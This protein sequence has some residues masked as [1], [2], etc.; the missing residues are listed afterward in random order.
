[1]PTK[2]A[3]ALT[4]L[5]LS[6]S[7]SG[8]P[9]RSYQQLGSIDDRQPTRFYYP[10]AGGKIEA[11]LTRPA[12]DGPFPLVILLHG[13]S[14]V[15]RGAEQVLATAQTFSREICFATLAISLPGYGGSDVVEGP[16]EE[17]TRQV[18]QDGVAFAKNLEWVDKSH[19]FFY[20]V[21]RGAI[22]AAAMLN[23]VEGISGAVLYSGAYDLGRL[24][25]DT[26]SFWVRKILNPKG[27]ANPKLFN[28]LAEG[29]Q[30]SVPTLILHGEQ[31]HVIPV[32]QARLLRDRLQ[33]AGVYHQLVVYPDRGHFLPRNDVRRRSMEF[34]KRFVAPACPQDSHL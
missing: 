15:G 3:L 7:C 27:A 26:P 33:S 25:R 31:D 22:I 24:Y 20:G 30:W 17:T 13:H 5:L 1:M 18:V 10:S 34:L 28:L 12:G 16:V 21:S 6:L 9:I 4:S 29:A 11:Y 8:A 2:K 14:F 23:D 19:L 32:N